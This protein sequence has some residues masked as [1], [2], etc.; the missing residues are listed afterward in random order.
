MYMRGVSTAA[1][2]SLIMYWATINDISGG[3]PSR[4]ANA[5]VMKIDESMNW[6]TMVDALFLNH[7][8]RPPVIFRQIVKATISWC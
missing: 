1:I 7:K 4:P 2:M 5:M 8:K 3:N 6:D